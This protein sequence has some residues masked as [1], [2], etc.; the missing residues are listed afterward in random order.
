[1]LAHFRSIILRLIAA[2]LYSPEVLA[3]YWSVNVDPCTRLRD[4]AEGQLLARTPVPVGG[5]V[6]VSDR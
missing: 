4:A 5:V 6:A 2:Q 1:M 3:R